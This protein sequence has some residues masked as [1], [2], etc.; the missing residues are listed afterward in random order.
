MDANAFPQTENNMRRQVG[1]TRTK[2]P[3][4]SG[5]PAGHEPLI[6][7]HPAGLLTKRG[8]RPPA[9]LRPSAGLLTRRGGRPSA[10]LLTIRGGRPSAGGRPKAGSWFI[11]VAIMIITYMHSSIHTYPHASVPMVDDLTG[12]L[13]AHAHSCT[14]RESPESDRL[15]TEIQ[16]RN[17]AEWNVQGHLTRNF[18][19]SPKMNTA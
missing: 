8:G 15:L 2:H 4:Q 6:V 12:C 16:Q 9:G 13:T 18:C 11:F 17:I 7:Q 1:M 19:Q 14:R 5:T 3:N 10:G